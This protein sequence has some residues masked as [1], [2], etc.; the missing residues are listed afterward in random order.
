MDVL[1]FI[2]GLKVISEHEV[3]LK[4]HLEDSE[5]T[6]DDAVKIRRSY[7][8]KNE[9]LTKEF[10]EMK[11][12]VAQAALDQAEVEQLRV[13]LAVEIKKEDEE[14]AQLTDDLKAER[15]KSNDLSQSK[16]VLEKTLWE[17]HNFANTVEEKRRTLSG[18]SNSSKPLSLKK[19]EAD[20]DFNFS[21]YKLDMDH[22][23]N[24]EEE[25]EED[26]IDEQALEDVL[27]VLSLEAASDKLP[28]A[29]IPA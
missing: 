22:P 3:N 2:D 24:H 12:M 13:D 16:E 7:S 21:R 8:K 10:D 27:Q 9:A 29:V 5:R 19:K 4:R 28:L 17:Y 6:W 15:K 25:E 11:V 20:G 1:Q 23:M 14:R 26:S 18:C